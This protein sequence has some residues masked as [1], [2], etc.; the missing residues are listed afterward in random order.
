MGLPS[1]EIIIFESTRTVLQNLR[2]CCPTSLPIPFS[3]LTDH[4]KAMKNYGG[5]RGK[6]KDKEEKKK[7]ERNME[8][9]GERMRIRRRRKEMM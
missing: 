5:G 7:Q 8:G 3:L 2:A 4:M 1:I 6:D 9:G